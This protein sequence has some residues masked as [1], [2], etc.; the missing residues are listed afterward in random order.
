MTG[1]KHRQG[2]ERGF[3]AYSARGKLLK[4]KI[5]G[6]AP[7]RNRPGYV[8]VIDKRAQMKQDPFR[9]GKNREHGSSTAGRTGRTVDKEHSRK[10]TVIRRRARGGASHVRGLSDER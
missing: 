10:K 4:R 5:R 9:G 8:I 2:S 1:T 3:P 7:E 6:Y